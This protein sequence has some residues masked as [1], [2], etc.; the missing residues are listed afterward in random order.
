MSLMEEYNPLKGEMLKILKPDGTLEPG[1]SP[2]IDDQET[3]KLYQK[4][5]FIRLADQ[6]CLSLQR[7][8]RFGTYAPTCR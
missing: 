7:Q 6:R 1:A 4:M 3:F 2:P 5:L 8:G